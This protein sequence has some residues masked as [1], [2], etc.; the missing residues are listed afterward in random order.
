M[1][2]IFSPAA[3]PESGFGPTSVADY[4]R[5]KRSFIV[6]L[7]PGSAQLLTA[8]QVVEILSRRLGADTVQKALQAE[9]TLESSCCG[10]VNGNWLKSSRM[11]GINVRTVG[12]FFNVVKY[13]LTLPAFHDSIHLLPIWEPGVVGSLYGMVSW[14]INPEFFSAELHAM[15]PGLNTPDAQLKATINLLHAMGFAVGMDVI[16][17]TDRFSEMVLA[18]PRFFEWVRQREGYL[19]DHKEELWREVEQLVYAFL[20]EFGTADGS[21]LPDFPAFFLT[22]ESD[23]TQESRLRMLFGHPANY[24]DRQ[25][26]RVALMRYVIAEGYETLPMTMAPPYRVLHLNPNHYT[27][28]E[29]GC[30]WYQYEFDEPQQMS[31]VFGPLTRYRLFNS[32]DSNLYWE[33]DFERPIIEVWE[34]VARNYADC[35]QKY[36]FDFMRGD[37]THVQMRQ[38]GVPSQLPSYYDLLAYVK[39]H[40][41]SEGCGYFA[42]FAESFLGAPDYMSYGDEI[43]HLEM[44][45][46]EVTL[47]DLQSTVVGSA[48]FTT[49]FRQYLD[50]AY[51]RTFK[52]SFTVITA[53][54]DDPRFDSFYQTGNLVRYFVALFMP[55]LPS[56][57]GA[58]FELRGMHKQ[59]AP[60]E[61]Y[62][63]LFVFQI[64]D[65]SES[66]KVTTGPYQWGQ[67][68]QHFYCIT[69]LREWAEVLVPHFS[70]RPVEWL[71]YPD[72]TLS[73]FYIAWC[74]GDYLFL[75]NLNGTD[76]TRHIS[77][78]QKQTGIIPQL[79]YT[80]ASEAG[81]D[82]PSGNGIFYTLPPLLPDEC[83]IYRLALPVT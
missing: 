58:G 43:A 39:R 36:N 50:I 82:T 19:L 56:Y 49:R 79:L 12:S 81:K 46:A 6:G 33:L 74:I 18:N 77:I 53:D 42:F 62:S 80:T 52:P 22:D 7:D 25:R 76:I 41:V 26:R 48:L 54:K 1:P 16:P 78:G 59:R 5:G 11:V 71:A 51:T 32:K 28:D 23:I 27:V 10:E 44:I 8:Y 31:R 72:P 68:R 4:E 57:V 29:A 15:M 13:A 63:K 35:R 70:G 73:C 61:A 14:E 47:G 64:S 55:E 66:D 30:R 83:R 34:Y 24:G 3:D 60:N 21:E 69:R 65:P 45:G 37:M 2:D 67:N 20:Q 38:E 40:I 17:H 9:S 75:C